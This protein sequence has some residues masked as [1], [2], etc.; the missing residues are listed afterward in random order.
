MPKIVNHD[1]QKEKVAEAAWRVIRREG[2]EGASVRK[3][4]EEAGISPGS[5]R[6]YFP[7]QSDLLLYSM[8][9]V[10]ERV[11]KRVQRIEFTGDPVHD[12]QLLLFELL[13]IDEEK[14]VEMEVWLIFNIKALSDSSL[15]NLVEQLYLETK[16]AITYIIDTFINQGLTKNNINRETEIQTLYALID[17]LTL[18]A[19]MRPQ[20]VTPEIIKNTILHHIRCLSPFS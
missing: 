19:I 3:I 12:A 10:T 9:L 15:Q 2:L 17:G 8:N 4:A 6:H 18:Q 20:Q 16:Q 7:T 13:P 14:S 11:K 5:M 1:K